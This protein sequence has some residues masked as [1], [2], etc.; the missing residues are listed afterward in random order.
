MVS[1]TNKK[2]IYLGLL[3]SL[4]IVAT[5]ISSS[6]SKDSYAYNQM[7]LYYGAS[8]WDGLST[9]IYLRE[10]FLLLASKILYNLG[11][12]ATLL[13]FIHA[14]ISLPV[15]FFLIDKHSKDKFLSLAYF[16]SYF[17]IL[18]DCTQLRFGMAVAFAYLGLHYLA[19]NRKLIFSGIVTVSAVLFHN[20]II[21]FIVMLLF[22]SKRS[23][24]WLLGMVIVSIML[25][26]LNL[27][28]VMLDFV[29][30]ILDY[31]DMWG[32]GTRL[33]KLHAYL[34]KP[35]SDMHLGIFS[36]HGLLIYFFGIVIFKYRNEFN[37]YET[38]CYNAFIL[39]VISWIL[40]KDSMDLQ[41]RAND[42]FGFS[43]VF[44]IPYAHKRLSE[45]VG[46]K[47]AYILLILFFVAYLA[48][49]VFYNKMV[50]L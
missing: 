21:V 7:F 29:G 17:F 6:F 3:I 8:G 4:I 12:G 23:L 44:L 49:F 9:E 27:N 2:H 1:E 18:H 45:Y 28:V 43:L 46:E 10:P 35:S 41:V 31:F 5:I 19:D 26:S 14:A 13:F 16:F 42:M 30:S 40:L 24:S 39:S 36:R 33:N 47:N 38:L 15:K 48:K 11:F 32:E 20:A 34:S 25:Y 22:T 50:S 37:K